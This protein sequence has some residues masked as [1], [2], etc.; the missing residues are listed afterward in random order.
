MR[1]LGGSCELSLPYVPG[2]GKN[3]W[4]LEAIEGGLSWMKDEIFRVFRKLRQ[5]HKPTWSTS[6]C[7]DGKVST[8]Q[9]RGMPGCMQ[10]SIGPR[11]LSPNQAQ[12]SSL[13]VDS[14]FVLVSSC[15]H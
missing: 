10:I 11:T 12:S 15:R 6:G 1:G 14:T 4:F 5:G 2:L 13:T 9:Q 7:L 3:R 8:P